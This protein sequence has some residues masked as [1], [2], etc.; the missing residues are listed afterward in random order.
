MSMNKRSCALFHDNNESKNDLRHSPH[1]IAIA[2][3]SGVFR[4]PLTFSR[5]LSQVRVHCVPTQDAIFERHTYIRAVREWNERGGRRGG[6]RGNDKSGSPNKYSESV[7]RA[8]SARAHGIIFTRAKL[9][10]NLR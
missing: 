3:E 7:E 1:A 5:G 2:K 9:D 4:H 10:F 8:E 6:T